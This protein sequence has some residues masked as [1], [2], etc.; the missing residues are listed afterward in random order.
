VDEKTPEQE[1]VEH[2]LRCKKGTI[3]EKKGLKSNKEKKVRLGRCELSSGESGFSALEESR[4]GEKREWGRDDLG[5]GP[6]KPGFT[7][8]RASHQATKGRK[9]RRRREIRNQRQLCRHR[10]GTSKKVT[11]PGHLQGCD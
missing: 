9:E 4:R 10:L 1:E 2:Q 8:F 6:P 7:G 11:G 5:K 3:R